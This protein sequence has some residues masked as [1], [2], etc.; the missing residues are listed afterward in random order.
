MDQPW[1]TVKCSFQNFGEE[2]QTAF[3]N[4]GTFISFNHFF[5]F[6][7]P[8]PLHS[9]PAKYH[10][11]FRKEREE[12]HSREVELSCYVQFYFA[13]WQCCFNKR[14]KIS[15]FYIHIIPFPLL[16]RAFSTYSTLEMVFS[17]KNKKTVLWGKEW[18]GNRKL[19]KNVLSVVYKNV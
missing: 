13:C 10:G 1:W 2:N 8:L 9:P 3:T 14:Q 5:P 7:T 18:E 19:E 6:T 11:L 17:E 4:Q 12:R 16:L 15:V